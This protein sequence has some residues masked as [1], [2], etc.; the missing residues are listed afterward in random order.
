MA[1]IEKTD[2]NRWWQSFVD[3]MSPVIKRV[4]AF[5]RKLPG[6]IYCIFVYYNYFSP[7]YVLNLLHIY[8]SHVLNTGM[9]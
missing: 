9:Q 5:S 1:E 8:I 2:P 4:V 3:N 6:I 7:L